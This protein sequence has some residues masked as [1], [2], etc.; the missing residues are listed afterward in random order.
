MKRLAI[1]VEG[2]TE[3]VFVDGLIREIAK[4]KNVEI[5]RAHIVGPRDRRRILSLGAVSLNSGDEFSVLIYNSRGDQNVSADIKDQYQKLI[6]NNATA[7]IGLMDVYPDSRSDI[8]KLMYYF[9]YGI[10]TKPINPSYVL[11]VMEIEAWFIAEHTH[12]PRIHPTLTCALIEQRTG[13][14]PSTDD[15]QLLNHPAANLHIF[16]QLVGKSYDKDPANSQQPDNMFYHTSSLLDY[17]FLYYILMDKIAPL[18]KL[19][20]AIEHF[21]YPPAQPPS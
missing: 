1:F 6:K 20:E 8:N 4:N 5:R 11:S 3:M 9:G 16:Y 7:I 14:D 19:I 21:F 13:Y 12:F 10:P 15:S 18:K 17:N 2:Y